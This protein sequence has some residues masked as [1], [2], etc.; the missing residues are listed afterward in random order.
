LI[1]ECEYSTW[2]RED[3]TLGGHSIKEEMCVNYIHY[4]PKTNL[5]VG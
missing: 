1:T 5:E 2:H 4:Y 3:I